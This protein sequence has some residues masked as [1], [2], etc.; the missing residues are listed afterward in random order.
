[1]PSSVGSQWRGPPSHHTGPSG[2]MVIER[3]RLHG[4]HHGH[5][6]VVDS[7]RT[8]VFQ[9]GQAILASEDD[10]EPTEPSFAVAQ[11]GS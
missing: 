2:P 7:A 1:M 6:T 3:A 8:H 11:S 10:E 4:R 5:T 9:Y